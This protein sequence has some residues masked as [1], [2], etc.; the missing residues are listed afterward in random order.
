MQ[1]ELIN[2]SKM[3]SMVVIFL[4]LG[5]AFA[6]Y[7]L[8]R[9]VGKTIQIIKQSSTLGADGSYNWSYDTENGISASEE[10]VPK[11][12]GNEIGNSVRGAYSYPS[13]NGEVVKIDYIS[14]ENG[15]QPQGNVLP[16][17]HPIPEYILRSLAYN[18]AHP[19]ENDPKP[20]RRY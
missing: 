14:D 10:G 4:V 9:Q 2:R 6:Q 5:C 11:R 19:E 20:G 18:A 17:P 15:F 8:P 7:R 1:S 13:P 12:I 3:K 16:T